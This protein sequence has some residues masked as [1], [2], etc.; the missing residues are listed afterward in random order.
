MK[1]IKAE[2]ATGDKK[3][4]FEIAKKVARAIFRGIIL[5]SAGLYAGLLFTRGNPSTTNT[6]IGR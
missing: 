2:E 1:I 4:K 5:G 6:I 3:K